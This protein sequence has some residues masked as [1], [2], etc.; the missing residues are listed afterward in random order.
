VVVP[1]S[2]FVTN[3]PDI[4]LQPAG[5]QFQVVQGGVPQGANT[6]FL[7]DVSSSSA[8]TWTATVLPGAS[9]LSITSQTG[10]STLSNP[11]SVAFAIDPVISAGLAPGAYYGRIEVTAAGVVNS[12][13]DFEVVLNILPPTAAQ[14]PALSPE[15]LLFI[16]NA[17]TAPPPQTVQV[18]ANS[19]SGAAF[20]ASVS[21]VNGQGWLSVSPTTGTA[22][23]SVNTAVSVNPAGLSAGVYRGSVTYAFAAAGVRTVNV[24]LLVLNPVSASTSG[25]SQQLTLAPRAGC[26]PKQL[27]P[28]QT[29]LVSNFSAAAAWPQPMAIN[30]VNDCGNPV[31]NGQIVATFSNGD[32]PLAL[33]LADPSAATYF[34]TWTPNHPSG[35]VTI[36]AN[37]TAAGLLPATV[38]YVG[39]VKPNAAPLL[40]PGATLHIFTPQVGEALGPGTI[41]QIYGQYLS[42]QT[43]AAS[44]IPLPTT[45]GGTQVIIGGIQAPIYFVSPGQI[46][47]E[48]PFELKANQLYQ[49][50]VNANGATATPDVVQ[51]TTVSPGIATYGSGTAIA[52]HGD[53]SLVT[54]AAPAKPGEY[55]VMYVSGFGSTTTPVASG[56]ASPS[57]PLAQPASTPTLTINGEQTTIL[58]AGLTP[59]LVGLYQ[60]NFQVPADAPNGDLN[61]V[62]SQA[63]IQSNSTILPVHK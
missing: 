24:T 44:T 26:T 11:G 28:A 19:S 37:A 30:L 13:L 49:I 54:E 1:V 62:L 46:N 38:Q 41:V 15:G 17:A 59:G 2:L 18:F 31:L 56:S 53:G 25:G 3:N 52:Q 48:V 35:Q 36:T 58:F 27:V 34:G 61:M 45:L 57:N 22:S 33:T 32:P 20:Q 40:T 10:T 23:P 6:S 16:T 42:S 43:T 55:L 50:I 51:L 63:G 9:W 7:V 60:V 14:Q 12:P 39:T 4:F 47:A 8:I 5:A 29:A 21:L